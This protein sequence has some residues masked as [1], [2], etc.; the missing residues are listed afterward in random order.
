VIISGIPGA[1]HIATEGLVI[2]Q[3]VTRALGLPVLEIVVPPVSDAS[4]GQLAARFEGFFEII[5]SR[6]HHG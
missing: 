5:R 1:S 4:S 6:R 3:E 2:R